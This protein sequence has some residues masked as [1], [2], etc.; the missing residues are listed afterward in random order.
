MNNL[1]PKG[2]HGMPG[3]T[4]VLDENTVGQGQLIREVI[5]RRIAAGAAVFVVGASID[6]SLLGTMIGASTAVGRGA[7]LLIVNPGS[8]ALSHTYN[9]VLHT[10]PTKV[11][12]HVLNFLADQDATAGH[13][14]TPTAALVRAIVSSLQLAGLPYSYLDLG[15]FVMKPDAI[16][17]LV[18]HMATAFPRSVQLG[19]LQQ[20]CKAFQGVDGD[21]CAEKL[22]GRFSGLAGSMCMLG[23]GRAGERVE[24]GH[25]FD[26][27]RWRHSRSCWSGGCDR[28]LSHLGCRRLGLGECSQRATGESESDSEFF[29][30]LPQI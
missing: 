24:H 5:Q 27:C 4:L 23:A 30:R 8:P 22:K 25:D 10:A 19:A 6:E 2:D 15:M 3:H 7:D 20:A 13:D 21:I 28:G 17:A 1:E 18:E 16:S 11:A 12:S 26:V 14:S 9:P 29:H